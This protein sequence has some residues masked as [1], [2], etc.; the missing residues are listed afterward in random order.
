MI[1]FLDCEFTDFIDCDLIAI[2]LIS[3][4]GRH[5]F[6]AERS[7]F[8]R[9]WCNAFVESTILP[10][11]GHD[12]S[13]RKSREQLHADLWDW[14]S[15]IGN[16]EIAY[17]YGVDWDLLMDALVDYEKSARPTN[18]VGRIDLRERMFD[19]IYTKAMNRF[20]A[21]QGPRH[22]ALADAQAHRAGWVA[23]QSA[24]HGD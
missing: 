9:S 19:P 23:W 15:V 24:Q 4:C 3:E 14:F 17:D 2:G 20:Y 12:E 10:L 8:E 13:A 22:H 5:M 16:V 11:L 6:Y 7:D 18:I 1:V 21:E